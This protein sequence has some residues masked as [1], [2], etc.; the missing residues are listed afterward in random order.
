MHLIKEEVDIFFYQVKSRNFIAFIRYEVQN[1]IVDMD[2]PEAVPY[3]LSRVPL[4]FHPWVFFKCHHLIL[5]QKFFTNCSF[6]KIFSTS[7]YNLLKKFRFK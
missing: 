4:Q 1:Y 3:Y 6:S 7:S 2:S 5:A